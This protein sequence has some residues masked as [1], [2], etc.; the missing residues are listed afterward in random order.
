MHKVELAGKLIVYRW[1]TIEIKRTQ[2]NVLEE[3]R[4][5]RR[6]AGGIEG[7]WNGEKIASRTS[8]TSR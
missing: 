3:R 6:V 5:A 8:N 7:Q 1:K 2:R 4:A